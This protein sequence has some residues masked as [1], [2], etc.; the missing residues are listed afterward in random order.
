MQFICPLQMLYRWERETPEK[1]YLHQP[2]QD[3]WKT[4]TWKETATEVRK[5][6]SAIRAMNLP[7][8]SRIALLSKNCAHW[9]LCDLAIMMSGHTSVPLYPNFTGAGIRQILD[10]SE[11]ALLFIGKV[12]NW[13]QSR[14]GIPPNIPCISFPGTKK[15]NCISWNDLVSKYEPLRENIARDKNEVG[16]IIYTSGTTGK[17]KGV[18]H[19]F[20]SYSFTSLNAIPYLCISNR[21]RFFSYLPLSHSAER[22]L[23]EMVSLY[24]GAEIYF[25]ESIEKFASNLSQAKPTV[26][27]GVHLIWKKMQ[28]RILEKIPQKKL[29]LFLKI[30]FLSSYIKR[31]IRKN[32][33]LSEASNIITGAAPTPV[34]LLRWY[35]KLGI[36]LQEGYG[37]TENWSYSHLTRND[38]IKIG[39]VGQ[40]LPG[41]TIRINEN[42]EILVKHEALMNGY[43]KEPELTAESFTP[44]GFLKTGDTG[45][46]CEDG[47]LR[48]TGRVKDIFKTSKAKYVAPAPIEMKIA[49]KDYIQATCVIGTGLPQPLALITLSDCGKNLDKDEL[50]LQLSELLSNLNATLEGHEKLSGIFVV[51]EE[52]TTENGLLT[53]SMKIKRNEVEKRYLE[54]FS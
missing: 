54:K 26:F 4:W 31:K 25:C 3:N 46:I 42:N 19:L 7:P 34:S 12:D 41:V 43:F 44:D 21:S 40:P 51:D 28:Q 29:D 17:P 20:N 18:V 37:L 14:E 11:A 27:L 50:H 8:N 10:H 2:I 35:E 15:E 13:Q 47:F 36:R 49:G 24:S 32:L 1:I 52:W 30:P 39:Y 33:G 6:A 48:I 9:I 53:P 22:S 16:T 38:R 23:V 5:M 45:E